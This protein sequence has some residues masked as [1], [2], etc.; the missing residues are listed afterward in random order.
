M[1][2]TSNY[3]AK[4]G[5][6]C[7]CWRKWVMVMAAKMV[8][9]MSVGRAP[10]HHYWLYNRVLLGNYNGLVIGRGSVIEDQMLAVPECIFLSSDFIMI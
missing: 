1:L 9:A 6:G 8:M 3:A 2:L 10:N 7:V 4:M 5:D